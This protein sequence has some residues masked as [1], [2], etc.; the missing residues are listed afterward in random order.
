V[1]SSILRRV[2]SDR[3]NLCRNNAKDSGSENPGNLNHAGDQKRD[4]R[5][6]C[7]VSDQ[8][9]ACEHMVKVRIKRKWMGT[10]HRICFEIVAADSIVSFFRRRAAMAKTDRETTSFYQN[11]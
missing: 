1:A 10:Y 2:R 11:L 9:V 7:L 3:H 6:L 4:P 5:L 8:P